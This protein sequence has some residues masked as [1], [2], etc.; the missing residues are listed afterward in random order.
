MRRRGL[1]GSVPARRL[2]GWLLSIVLVLG[3]LAPAGHGAIHAAG[4]GES[5]VIV[6]CTGD[7][8]KLVDLETGEQR[9]LPED[10]TADARGCAHCPW[11]AGSALRPATPAGA[12]YDC[13]QV[14]ALGI[15]P[16]LTLVPASNTVWSEAAPRAPPNSPLS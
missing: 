7:G 15:R 6:I 3:G 2:I 16:P 14:S 11:M 13:E 8:I 9:D 12:L 10:R 1:T 4:P 5:G